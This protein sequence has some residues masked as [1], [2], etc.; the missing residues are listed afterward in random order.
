[1]AA[2]RKLKREIKTQTGIPTPIWA[3]PG[4][5]DWKSRAELTGLTA[6]KTFARKSNQEISGAKQAGQASV[7]RERRE[8]LNRQQPK[9]WDEQTTANNK[10]W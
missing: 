2:R 5:G 7:R 8:I 6:R 3:D 4:C 1:L 9:S 10:K